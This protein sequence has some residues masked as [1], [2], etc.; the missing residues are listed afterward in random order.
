MSFPCKQELKVDQHM[1]H[2]FIMQDI[3]KFWDKRNNLNICSE[4]IDDGVIDLFSL[5]DKKVSQYLQKW[6]RSSLIMVIMV[7]D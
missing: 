3:M 2:S 1:L 7:T 5:L 6:D 4:M